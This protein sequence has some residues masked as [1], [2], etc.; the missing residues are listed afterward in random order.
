MVLEAQVNRASEIEVE[1]SLQ[2]A[3]QHPAPAQGLEEEEETEILPV[4]APAEIL[5]PRGPEVDWTGE[6][7]LTPPG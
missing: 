2:E 4:Q 3:A 5:L 1:I 6:C 7:Q